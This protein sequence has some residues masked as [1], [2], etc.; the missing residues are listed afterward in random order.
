MR[1]ALLSGR[2]I[3]VPDNVTFAFNPMRVKID[4]AAGVISISI[5]DGEQTFTDEREPIGGKVAFDLSLYARSFF[6]IDRK[7][8]IQ[9]KEVTCTITEGLNEY[10]FTTLVIWGA[11]NVGERFNKPR[12]VTWFKNF[13]FTFTLYVPQGAIARTRYDRNKYSSATLQ[14]G[15]NVINPNELFNPSEFGVIR[16]DKYIHPSV[17]EYTF[18]ETFRG[19]DEGTHISRLVVDECTKGIYLRWIDR[20]GYYQYYLF[21]GGDDVYQSKAQGD[22]VNVDYSSWYD[23]GDIQV[24]QHKQMTNSVRACA[25]LVDEETFKMLLG[26]HSSPIVNMWYDNDWLPIRVGDATIT[27][28]GKPLQDVEIEIMLPNIVSQKL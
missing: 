27:K 3:L 15:L 5:T 26:I 1:E 13:P 21:K 19:M 17:W 10:T 2:T 9:P 7:T 25:T 6:A 22:D 11:M 20:H 18:D 12:T 16:M 14:E 24:Q 23:F 4:D 28:N 8:M